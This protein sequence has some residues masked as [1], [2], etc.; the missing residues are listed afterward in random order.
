MH[1]AYAYAAVTSLFWPPC[2]DAPPVDVVWL[3]EPQPAA[4]GASSR[5]RSMYL[6]MPSVLGTGR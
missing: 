3:F 5:A 4:I 1:R 6:V 2:A